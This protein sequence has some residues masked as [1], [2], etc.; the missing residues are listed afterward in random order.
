MTPTSIDTGR[1][2]VVCDVVLPPGSRRTRKYC[3]R[4]C[5]SKANPQM[6]R[7]GYQAQWRSDNGDRVR[8]NGRRYIE[9]HR[10]EIVAKQRAY[11]RAN[12]AQF[13]AKRDEWR[14]K[15]PDRFRVQSQVAYQRRRA[16]LADGP[17]VS[18]RDW[19][20]MLARFRWCCAYCGE[21]RADL[22]MEHV[23]PLARGGRHSIG[24]VLPACPP[25]NR[26]KWSR[27]L[28]EW[29]HAVL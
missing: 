14:R 7:P 26:S 8:A 21:R 23:V 29:R 1:A 22:Q 6:P 9:D 25:C 3:S 17:G 12:R 13:A 19:C 15:N 16:R 11:Y 5:K 4:R 2:C 24:N 28:V 18:T 27:L 20:R 10:S